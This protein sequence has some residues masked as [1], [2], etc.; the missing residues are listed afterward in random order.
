MST[1]VAGGAVALLNEWYRTSCASAS[2][3]SPELIRALFVHTADDLVDARFYA[4]AGPDYSSGF[5]RMR[6][7]DAVDLTA[8]HIVGSLAGLTSTYTT[9]ITIPRTRPLKVTLAWSDAAW[10]PSVGPGPHGILDND[11]DLLLVG[12]DGRQYGPWI[13]DPKHPELPATRSSYTSGTSPTREVRNTI[14]QVVVDDAAAGTW[15]VKVSAGLMKYGPQSFALVSEAFSPASSPCATTP[16][17]DV[18]VRDNDMD[19]GTT[20]SSNP[21]YL[22]PD[23]WNRTAAD[24]VSEHQNPQ[25]GQRNF[26]YANIRNRGANTVVSTTVELWLGDASTGLIWPTSYTYVGRVVVPNLTP[27]EVRQVGPVAWSPPAPGHYCMY[28]RLLSAQDPLTSPEG[29][30]VM[31]NARNNNNIAYRNLTIVELNSAAPEVA[32]FFLR[33]VDAQPR[34]VDLA[35]RV[36]AALLQ[37]ARVEIAMSSGLHGVW[38]RR[39]STTVGLTRALGVA[40]IPPSGP[41]PP[42]GP[43]FASSGPGV[44]W[45]GV[46]L[47]PLHTGR[48]TLTFSSARRDTM[49][50]NVDVEQRVGNE[51]VGGIRYVVRTGRR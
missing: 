22:G 23:L 27:G 2:T 4:G 45:C 48:V 44:V 11:L 21:L 47:G 39:D 36:P 25:F 29:A 16:S 28:M 31:N 46:R 5:G 24:G 34:D 17:G 13:L 14:E 6:V 49:T 1:G 38:T 12:P 18:W 35:I 3:L 20:P 51:V 15:T 43:A 33:N 10:D 30:S 19:V 37:A 9:T 26:L 40:L 41:Q 42:G 50:F 7:K 32:T 8:H